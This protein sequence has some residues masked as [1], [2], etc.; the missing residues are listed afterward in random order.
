MGKNVEPN[1]I[2]EM[3][4]SMR[5]TLKDFYTRFF[6]YDLTDEQADMILA[7]RDPQR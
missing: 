7:H 2:V 1:L 4:F 5:D 6:R 3:I